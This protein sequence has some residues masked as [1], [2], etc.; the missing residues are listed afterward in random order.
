M[1][2]LDPAT[3]PK[4]TIPSATTIAEVPEREEA[5][6]ENSK[7]CAD[8]VN[9]DVSKEMKETSATVKLDSREAITVSATSLA[10]RHA[11]HNAS[12][13]EMS[14]PIRQK[15]LEA[16]ST[17]EVLFNNKPAKETG[18]T[19]SS[20]TSH[21]TELTSKLVEYDREGDLPK[22]QEW[23]ESHRQHQQQN[24]LS[25]EAEIAN[26]PATRSVSSRRELLEMLKKLRT[27]KGVW[28]IYLEKWR[29]IF[30][31]VLTKPGP[32]TQAG[33]M[34]IRRLSSKTREYGSLKEGEAI[35]L[36]SE[37]VKEAANVQKS[38]SLKEGETVQSLLEAMRSEFDPGGTK[39]RRSKPGAGPV[40][41]VLVPGRE[42]Q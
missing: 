6:A 22:Y 30:V 26:L 12:L 36:A 1:A 25:G 41:G 16:S 21:W 13:E 7:H 15:L 23:D 4:E 17:E 2:T 40:I 34:K 9:S 18:R 28:E 14:M 11:K 35:N 20:A 27:F 32:D 31:P 5:M 38:S 39:T 37:V 3:Q 19:V 8:T 29:G 42:M 10:G 24:S 33:C